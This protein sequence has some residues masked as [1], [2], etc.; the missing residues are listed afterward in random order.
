M[1]SSVKIFIPL[2]LLLMLFS[3]AFAEDNQSAQEKSVTD[4]WQAESDETVALNDNQRDNVRKPGYRSELDV[5]ITVL[6]CHAHTGIPTATQE[7][8]LEYDDIEEVD[9][10]LSTNDYATA[11]EMSEYDVVMT[12]SDN[13]YNEAAAFGDELADYIDG[14]GAFVPCMFAFASGGLMLQ[15]RVVTDDYLPFTVGNAYQSG[16]VGLGDYEEGHPIME[17]VEAFQGNYKSS[18]VTVDND[19]ELVASYANDWPLV[20]TL[21][22]VVAINEYFGSN[23]RFT[24]DG[25]LML[26]NALVYAVEGGGEP[27]ATMEGTVTDAVTGDAVEDAIV[28]AS[29]GRD[30]TDVNGDYYLEGVRS[31][32]DRGVRVI[33]EHYYT[34]NDDIDIEVGEN[35][36]DFEITP[37]A[38]LTGVITDSETDEVVEGAIISWG[39]HIDT[40]D[41]DGNY[42]LIDLEA[43]IDTLVIEAEG[44]FDYEDLE[45]EVVDGDNEEDFAIDILSG[46]LTGVV[47]DELT[48]E[49]LFGATVT[50]VNSETGDIYRE[51]TT[52]ETGAY[53]APALHDGVTYEVSVTLDGYAPSDVE[54]VLIRWN[55][56]NEQDFELTP[57]FELGIRQLQQEQDLETWVLTSGI[58]T[59]G[60]NV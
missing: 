2:A 24:G 16:L 28:R 13:T 5:P 40:T 8:L 32:E 25:I 37:L 36:F 23:R 30:T 14:G 47:T 46:D 50:V 42:T 56:D 45:Y 1:R 53:N 34:Y 33:T 55:R 10:F 58:V 11:E 26:K 57:I 15:G 9:L 29:G 35:F 38:T 60:T 18:N 20:A 7:E 51:V 59:Q 21:G 6:I 4:S 22:T 43:A 52:D 27:D 19:G 12:Y 17:D 39:E 41:V 54:D 3:F 44:Y 31:G 48:E 49:Q